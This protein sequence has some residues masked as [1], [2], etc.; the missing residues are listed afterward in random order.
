M[1]TINSIKVHIDDMTSRIVIRL[2]GS[3]MEK[4]E[5]YVRSNAARSNADFVRSATLRA[6]WEMENNQ[7]GRD[8]DTE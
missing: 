6:I 2:S 8:Q 7:K 3:D 5:G 4:I 1:R